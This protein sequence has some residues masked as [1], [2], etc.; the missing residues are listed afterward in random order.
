MAIAV[1]GGLITSTFVTLFVVPALSL[2]PADQSR[3]SALGD[4]QYA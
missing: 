3:A 4:E 2:A 1:L